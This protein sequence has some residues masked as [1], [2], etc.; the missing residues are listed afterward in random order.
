MISGKFEFTIDPFKQTEHLKKGLRNKY[1]RIAL[2]KASGKIKDAVIAIAPSNTGALKKSF[3]IKVKNYKN[4]DIWV[5]IV[6]PKSDYTKKKGKYKRGPNKGNPKIK[7]PSAYAHLLERGTKHMPKRP[8][9][10]PALQE[11]KSL[12]LET[13]RSKIK[14]Q[15][16]AS[17]PNSKA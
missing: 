11:N 6:G 7:R 16:Q 8:F 14:E 2:N 13:L 1:I 10:N 4:R 12:F 5:A 9:L 15:V 3:R 17:L